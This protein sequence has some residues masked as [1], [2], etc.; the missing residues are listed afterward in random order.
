MNTNTHRVLVFVVAVIFVV[1]FPAGLVMVTDYNPGKPLQE[2][3][4]NNC[5]EKAK[6][7][8]ANGF[9]FSRK[10]LKRENPKGFSTKV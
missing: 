4:V 10:T 3:L 2:S 7:F 1:L 8:S 5:P 6:T 9:A